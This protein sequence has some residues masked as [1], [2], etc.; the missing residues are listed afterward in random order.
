MGR[1][2]GNGGDVMDEMVTIYQTRHGSK[3][4]FNAMC[5][6]YTKGRKITED[7][8]FKMVLEGKFCRKC[9]RDPDKMIK[10]IKAKVAKRKVT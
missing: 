1:S 7:E 4:H 3:I 8:F 10:M 9:I 2:R 6:T 5:G